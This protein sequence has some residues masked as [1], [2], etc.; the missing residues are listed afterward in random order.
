MPVVIRTF[1]AWKYF[2]CWR[3]KREKYHRES[4]LRRKCAC[5]VHL[6]L[7]VQEKIGYEDRWRCDEVK[8]MCM[9]FL[10]CCGIITGSSEI[11]YGSLL[12]GDFLLR[13]EMTSPPNVLKCDVCGGLAASPIRISYRV[14][15]YEHPECEAS[16]MDHIPARLDM[17]GKW[18]PS[19]LSGAALS[20]LFYR[21][22]F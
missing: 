18:V 8:K 4:G 13:L 20:F 2:V 5:N 6:F 12:P 10:L 3:K 21:G 11:V 9:S 7:D 1:S 15:V 22:I 17:L 14:A 19:S 16:Y